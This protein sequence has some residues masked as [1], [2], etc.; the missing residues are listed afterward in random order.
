MKFTKLMMV[1]AV[2]GL[3]SLNGCMLMHTMGG[4]EGMGM[5]DG[6]MH[7]SDDEGMDMEQM[8]HE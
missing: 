2:I 5:H 7:S 4:D 8:N 6:M 1:A 3:L